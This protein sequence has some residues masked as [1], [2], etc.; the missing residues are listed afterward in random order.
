MF[1]ATHINPTAG[2][3]HGLTSGVGLNNEALR[4]EAMG[5]LEGAERMHLRAIE[6]KEASLGPGDMTTAV[7]YNGLG[8]LYLTMQRLDKAEEYLNKALRVREHSGPKS[9]LSVTRDNLAKLYEM[10]GNLQAAQEMRLRGKADDNI[11][12]G[13]YNVSPRNAYTLVND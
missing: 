5:D 9:D 8:E 1:N 7:S 2:Q 4:L 6:V 10:K 11:A 13:N 12:C 3:A